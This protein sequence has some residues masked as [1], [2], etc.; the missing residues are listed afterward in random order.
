MKSPYTVH[1]RALGRCVGLVVEE[2]EIAV[3]GRTGRFRDLGFGHA[4]VA[5]LLKSALLLGL[6][7][8]SVDDGSEARV[9][10]AHVARPVIGARRRPVAVAVLGKHRWRCNPR[11]EVADRK[12]TRLNSSH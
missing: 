9:G 8:L 6:V 2:I 5:L 1:G 4:G 7:E 10:A 3:A 12:S 11:R